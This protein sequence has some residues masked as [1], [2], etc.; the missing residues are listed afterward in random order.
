MGSGFI[1]DTQSASGR[2]G[3]AA[4][5][6]TNHHVIRDAQF[7]NVTV[8]DRELYGAKVVED[9]P[10]NDIALIEI[11]CGDFKALEW[12]SNSD[13][14]E[15]KQA[16][17]VGYP[18]GLEGKATVTDGIILAA[19]F[20][21]RFGQW[22]IQTDAAINPGNS[23]GP[24]VSSEGKL[25]GVNTRGRVQ[26][27]G[28]GYAV[29]QRTLVYVIDRFARKGADVVDLGDKVTYHENSVYFLGAVTRQKAEQYMDSLIQRGRV[30]PETERAWQ[31]RL[32]DGEYELRA[33]LYN[34]D[35]NRYLT[36]AKQRE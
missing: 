27:D 16:V 3:K 10:Y 12:A 1:I 30:T 29:S 5:I 33:G 9:D 23:G 15:G 34:V 25:L 35:E 11:C 6:V 7:I 4:L 36:A 2:D 18:F 19:R 22:V 24:L 26:A 32:V 20:D 17:A 14:A 8:N 13:V 28:I 31:I 21:N